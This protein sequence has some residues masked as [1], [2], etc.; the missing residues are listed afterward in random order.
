MVT[1]CT[2]YLTNLPLFLPP[3]LAHVKEMVGPLSIS[4]KIV[5]SS[6]R[7]NLPESYG[8]VMVKEKSP[9]LG[10]LSTEV[11]LEGSKSMAGLSYS[12]VSFIAFCRTILRGH[13]TDFHR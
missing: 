11:V 9:M 7:V 1:S 2:L 8:M 6:C 10:K 13:G 4:H 12:F 3:Y 5:A